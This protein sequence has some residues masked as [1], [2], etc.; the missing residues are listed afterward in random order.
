MLQLQIPINSGGD[1]FEYE[2]NGPQISIGRRHD[3]DIRIK[4]TYIS[5]YHAELYRGDD[6]RYFLKDRDSSNGTFHNG[7]KVKGKV[8]VSLGDTLKFGRLKCY[9]GEAS[10]ARVAKSS[11]PSSRPKSKR[12]N[13]SGG[14]APTTPLSRENVFYPIDKQKTEKT[15]SIPELNGKTN[16][17]R[18]SKING[19]GNG[20][21]S[22]GNGSNGSN[23]NGSKGGYDSGKE[24]KQVKERLRL[25]ETEQET[26]KGQ[27]KDARKELE[28]SKSE[29]RSKSKELTAEKLKVS[30]L[31]KEHKESISTLEGNLRAK[32]SET[33]K[34]ARKVRSAISEVDTLKNQLKH[35]ENADL[36]EMYIAM[37]QLE[38]IKLENTSLQEGFDLLQSERDTLREQ[39]LELTDKLKQTREG[40]SFFLHKTNQ[41]LKEARIR[42]SKLE[43][44]SAV[45][46]GKA[47][48][49]TTELAELRQLVEKMKAD[50][51]ERLNAEI[52]A[53]VEATET[54]E[55]L[56]KELDFTLS[57]S[58]VERTKLASDFKKRLKSEVEAKKVA[59]D[60]AKTVQKELDSARKGL[61]D[62]GNRLRDLE[63][64]LGNLKQEKAAAEESWKRKHQ[65]LE[66]A[67]RQLMGMSKDLRSFEARV[68][69]T[70]SKATE[71]KRERDELLDETQ[72]LAEEKELLVDEITRL[73]REH[74]QLTDKVTG[75]RD[76][77]EK[78][79]D[80]L[81]HLMAK[82]KD[83]ERKVV[84]LRE[85]EN[86]LERSVV[87]AHRSALSR[88]GIY[89]ENAEDTSQIWPETEELI[90]RELIEKMELLEDLLKAYQQRRFFPKFAEQLHLLQDSFM[91]LLRNHSVD[92]FDLEPG[93]E[94]SV[95]S[96]KKIQL[97]SADDL[98]DP[99]IKKISAQRKAKNGRTTV[100]ETVR[101]GYVYR[102][103]GKDI[104][105]RKAE[106][107]VA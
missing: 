50:H 70:G 17:S 99:R 101:P 104:I 61:R 106:V 13:F 39:C 15:A 72:D 43:T 75:D 37:E 93:T 97:I 35:G 107:I 102:N 38:S 69:E 30:D 89:S 86:S 95:E 82:M 65:E 81:D 7:R 59:K 56:Q 45:A 83:S 90:C 40:F 62:N 53:R 32:E 19:N 47:N 18:T 79:A 52:E 8:A 9:I 36:A 60:S 11:G 21:G 2:L 57:N 68:T 26:L 12:G 1:V 10:P 24:L 33:N 6:G 63:K 80:R 96:R 48:S 77:S 92:R 98:G 27:L 34:L 54:A 66:D 58:S 28:K 100:L 55:R 73:T 5:A 46:S 49:S 31:K 84:H 4:E 87:R 42:N 76:E 105:I 14:D 88:R 51:K 16:G 85:L 44:D 91:A 22:N 64:L 78:V 74:L 41:R 3:N 103:G 25:I 94:L 67:N 29:L 20:N 23:G 71:L